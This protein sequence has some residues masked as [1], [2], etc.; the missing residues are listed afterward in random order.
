MLAPVLDPLDRHAG[1][2][3]GQRDQGNVGIHRRL[4]PEAAADVGRHDEAQPVLGHPQHARDEPVHDEGPHEVRPDRVGLVHVVPARD[5]PV[6]LDG[7]GPVLGEAEALADDDVRLREGPVGIAVDE[8]PVARQVRAH[9]LVEDRRVGL[10]GALHVHDRGQGLVPDDDRLRRVLG[11]IA[12]PRHHHR[13][14][15]PDE[16]DLVGGRAV[17]A[18][19]RGDADREGPGEARHVLAG[20]D[21]DHALHPERRGDVVAHDARVGVR[22]AHDGGGVD[23]AERGMIVDEVAAAGEQARVLDARDAA[24]DPARRLFG[25]RPVYFGGRFSRNEVTPSA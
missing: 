11:Q 23:V 22:R 6:G 4:D 13:H 2:P 14:R 20:D 5:H 1:A 9:R 25:H 3:S 8:P 7:G 24:A 18:H 19:R 12:A 16:A 17:V 10:E 15:L 21:A